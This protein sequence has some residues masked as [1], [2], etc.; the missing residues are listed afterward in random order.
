MA[1]VI[2]VDIDSL[3]AD[4]NAADPCGAASVGASVPPVIP[5]PTG[6]TPPS[7][8]ESFREA[9]E[10]RLAVATSLSEPV[11]ETEVVIVEEGMPDTVN[12]APPVESPAADAQP[13]QVVLKP[14]RI[15]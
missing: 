9:E 2:V 12:D 14:P 11:P 13:A 8:L 7:G 5:A 4:A 1:S 10:L 3:A 6:D 15:Q